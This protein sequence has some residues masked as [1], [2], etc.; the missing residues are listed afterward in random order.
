MLP[1]YRTT[2]W[3]DGRPYY[4]ADD[5]YYQWVPSINTYTIVAPPV[6]ADEP[7]ASPLTEPAEMAV[8]NS[9][10]MYPK[11]GQTPE[12]QA[13]DRYECH[14][15]AKGQTGFD[16]TSSMGGVTSEENVPKGSEYD[17]AMIACFDAREY[18]VK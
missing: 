17:R 5:T 2:V 7:S 6:A 12:Q 10:Y 1:S 4:Y 16:P 11:N 8:R 3:I 18:S 13:A 9:L 14:T 15:W